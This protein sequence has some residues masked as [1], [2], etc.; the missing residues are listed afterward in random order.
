MLL[1]AL[2]MTTLAGL[3]TG[4]GGLLVLWKCPSNRGVSL[5]LGFAGGVMLTV[6]LADLVPSGMAYYRGFLPPFAAGCAAGSLILAG[7]A[8]AGLLDGILPDENKMMEKLA[9]DGAKALPEQGFAAG[10]ESDEA[11]ALRARALHCGI[12]VGL[13]LLLHNLPEGILTLFTSVADPRDGL[14]VTIAIALHN[15]PEGISVATPLWYATHSRAK[16]AGAAFLSGLAEPAGALLA[17]FL[18]RG[19]LTEGFLNGLTLLVAGVMSWVSCAELLFGGFALGEKKSAAIGFA[20][21][22][23]GMILG[24]A[25]LA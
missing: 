9:R 3:S 1:P 8:I 23:G 12:A 19:F 14:R 20:L 16:S 24:I 2:L 15:I 10:A 7:M 25:A 21:G 4:L 13:A 18:L 11:V 22:V 17:Y 5:A 6:S